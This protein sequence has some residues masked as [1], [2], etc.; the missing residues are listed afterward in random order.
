MDE[1]SPIEKP[2]SFL[3]ALSDSVGFYP[4]LHLPNLRKVKLLLY[5]R[6]GIEKT[7]LQRTTHTIQVLRSSNA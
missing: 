6:D 2:K 5:G 1:L 7:K 4:P 3:D